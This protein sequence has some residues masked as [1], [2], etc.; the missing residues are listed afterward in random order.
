MGTPL[1]TTK[2]A[3][4]DLF[5]PVPVAYLKLVPSKNTSV[6]VGALLG[7]VGATRVQN[8]SVMYAVAYKDRRA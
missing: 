5:G 6:L 4:T 3:V 2:K 8:N 7:L 1:I